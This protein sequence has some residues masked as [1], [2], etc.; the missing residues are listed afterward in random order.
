MNAKTA[1]TRSPFCLVRLRLGCAGAC[2]A[3]LEVGLIDLHFGLA[4]ERGEIRGEQ[5][6]T[7]LIADLVGDGLELLV[8]RRRGRDD[9][10]QLE[11]REAALIVGCADILRKLGRIRLEDALDRICRYALG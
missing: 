8:V 7:E 10:R 11:D 4:L 2:S 9:L 1:T 6:A 5:L 3:L